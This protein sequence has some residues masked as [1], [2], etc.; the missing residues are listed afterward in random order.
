MT[1][2][3]NVCHTTSKF[4]TCMRI[5]QSSGGF[6]GKNKS[7]KKNVGCVKLVHYDYQTFKTDIRVESWNYQKW[8]HTVSQTDT[9]ITNREIYLQPP[10][11]T[12]KHTKRA[13]LLLIRRHMNG[14]S[15]L[16]YWDFVLHSF[17]HEFQRPAG[18][19]RGFK[20]GVTLR[21]LP[22]Q[23]TLTPFNKVAGLLLIRTSPFT[24]CTC[25]KVL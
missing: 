15:S 20:P 22:L 13:E 21:P 19:R 2:C 24:S 10:P 1:A 9:W 18:W 12:H 6:L 8:R 11:Q 5:N 17:K 3:Y 16:Y 14:G 23:P 25:Q 4:P 7:N